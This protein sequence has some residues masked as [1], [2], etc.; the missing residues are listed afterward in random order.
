MQQKYYILTHYVSWNGGTN[1]VQV[2]RIVPVGR[3]W[4]FI[5]L[6]TSE[7]EMA[8]VRAKR[9]AKKENLVVI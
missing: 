4:G 5:K 9:W 3:A 1:N 6:F 2:S 7:K 8:E